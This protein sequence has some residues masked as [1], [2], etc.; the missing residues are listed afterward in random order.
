MNEKTFINI[1]GNEETKNNSKE[2]E[3]KSTDK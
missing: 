1:E 2:E 3:T